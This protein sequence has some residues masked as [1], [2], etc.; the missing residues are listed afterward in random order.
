MYLQFFVLVPVGWLW[1][2]AKHTHG[3]FFTSL[4]RGGGEEDNT[5]K[6]IRELRYVESHRWLKMGKQSTE[7]HS[8]PPHRQTNALSVSEQLLPW[9]LK[10]KMKLF[11][12]Y[13]SFS[14]KA[15]QYILWN[16]LLAS[17]GQLS[18]L[19]AFPNSCLPPTE[20]NT[21]QPAMMK[22]NATL[23]RPRLTKCFWAIMCCLWWHG[24]IGRNSF[25]IIS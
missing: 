9:K 18:W 22:A 19:C 8:L 13:L 1:P 2:V 12:S 20:Q 25:W 4:P 24:V 14:Y 21:I 23:A 10:K 3:C 6:K 16:I 5:G 15:L 17:H 7:N 11:F